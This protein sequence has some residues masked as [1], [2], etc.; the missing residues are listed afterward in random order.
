MISEAVDSSILNFDGVSKEEVAGVSQ[1]QIDQNEGHPRL[2]HAHMSIF[3]P[4]KP[5]TLGQIWE[6]TPGEPPNRFLP[7]SSQKRS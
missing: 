7:R 4:H 1:R 6:L 5:S 2:P 3:L